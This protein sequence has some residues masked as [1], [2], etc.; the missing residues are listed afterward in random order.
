MPETVPTHDLP[1]NSSANIR[2][3]NGNCRYR[4]ADHQH[5]IGNASRNLRDSFKKPR[6]VKRSM[7]VNVYKELNV[8]VVEGRLMER[9]IKAPQ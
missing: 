9:R 4:P 1:D 6:N 7:S 3:A 8:I 5:Q 2:P